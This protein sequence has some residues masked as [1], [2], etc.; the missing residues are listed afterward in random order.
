[1]ADFI[2]PKR[3]TV[4]DDDGDEKEFVISKFDC[5]F[6][7]EAATQY[8]MT[9]LPKIG[10]YP[11]NEELMFR[12]LCFAAAISADGNEIPLKSKALVMNHCTDWGMLTS[13]EKELMQYN[14]SFLRD[15]R[16]STFFELLA[17]TFLRKISETLTP[18]SASSSTAE[19]PLSTN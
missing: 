5:I 11:A 4:K 13:L 2:K 10:D 19:K 7:R 1:M 15:G 6:G 12:A 9:A 17:Q 3:V 14:I 8:L 16:I 18:S